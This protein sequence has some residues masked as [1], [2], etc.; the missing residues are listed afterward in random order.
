MYRTGILLIALTLMSSGLLAQPG[1]NFAFDV[2]VNDTYTI[3]PS[4]GSGPHGD[5]PD[6]QLGL[7][8]DDAR[9]FVKRPPDFGTRVFHSIEVN[10]TNP[11][12]AGIVLAYPRAGEYFTGI[13]SG[14]AGTYYIW[15]RAVWL[16]TATSMTEYSTLQGYKIEIRPMGYGVTYPPPPGGGGGG[17]GGGG[18]GGD[19]ANCSTVAGANLSLPAAFIS[20]CGALVWRRRRVPLS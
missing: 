19:D 6:G 16:N 20:V 9:V 10:T 15:M 17:G 8:Y 18:S 2:I 5:M 12:P 14:A 4:Y 13:P 11:W 7:A 1:S 3:T